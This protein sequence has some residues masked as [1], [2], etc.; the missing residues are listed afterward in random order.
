M[1]S[2]GRLKNVKRESYGSEGFV[3]EVS[4]WSVAAQEFDFK[5]ALNAFLERKSLL[6]YALC[7]MINQKTFVGSG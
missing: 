3:F 7:F 5:V 1:V 4:R 6:K 2:G